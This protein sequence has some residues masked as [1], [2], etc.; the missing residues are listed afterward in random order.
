MLKVCEIYLFLFYN[1]GCVVSK[2]MLIDFFWSDYDVIK[3]SI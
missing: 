1:L 3:V 2:D